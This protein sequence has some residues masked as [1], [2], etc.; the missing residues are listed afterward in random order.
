MFKVKKLIKM[1]KGAHFA[2]LEQPDLLIEDIIKFN[3]I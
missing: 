2:V 1:P 3:S